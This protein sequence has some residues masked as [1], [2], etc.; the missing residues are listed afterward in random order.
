MVG[1]A[2]LSNRPLTLTLA[3]E[4]L[5][6]TLM[7]KPSVSIEDIAKAVSARFSVKLSDLQGKRRTKSVAL[8]RQICMHIARKLTEYSLEEIGGFFGGRDHTTVLYANDKISRLLET[9]PG[10]RATVTDIQSELSRA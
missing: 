7:A 1:F 10:I 4:A 2:A 5:Q 9:D 6:E 3:Q 8:P